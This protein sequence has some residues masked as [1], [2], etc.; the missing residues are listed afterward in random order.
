MSSLQIHTTNVP[1]DIVDAWEITRREREEYDYLDWEAIEAGED[2]AEFVR[3]KGGLYYLG[4]FI[5]TMPGPFNHG[6]PAEFQEWDG[7][8]SDSYF[9]GLLIRWPRS[10]R[11]EPDFTRVIVGQ[12]TC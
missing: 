6:L 11:G 5:T 7:Y 1:R 8:M 9:S 12:Y 3:Y 2:S 10:D 4:D